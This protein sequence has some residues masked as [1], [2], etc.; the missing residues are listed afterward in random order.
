MLISDKIRLM[1]KSLLEIKEDYYEMINGY[2][3]FKYII[4]LNLYV[5]HAI[6]SK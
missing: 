3:F 1:A 5:S 6:T 4:V 2:I